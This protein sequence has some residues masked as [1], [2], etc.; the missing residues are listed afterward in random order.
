MVQAEPRH[1][2]GIH[3]VICLANG[4][5]V[6]T[7]GC[8]SPEE[9]GEMLRRFPGGHFVVVTGPPHEERVIGVALAM[10]TDYP[11]S[12]RPLSWWEMIGDLTLP[13]HD[14][15][16]R[17][18][19]GVDKAVLP[20]FQGRGVA[21]ALYKAQFA[22]VEKLGLFGMYAGGM[23][24]GYGR[25]R[26]VMSVREYAAKVISGELFDPTVSV[27]MKRGFKPCGI[28]ENYAWDS[29]SEHTGMLIVWQPQ[30]RA[31]PTRTPLRTV[32][33]TRPQLSPRS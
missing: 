6:G 32:T 4:Y 3:E 22:L 18:L 23:L 13:N 1:G 11:P 10:R 2:P 9:V 25:H 14:P 5:P 31:K 26:S 8:A 33:P 24:K 19:Y 28:I 29:L 30:R 12:A 17:W 27:Q 15:A 7:R 20:E 21:S 16:G